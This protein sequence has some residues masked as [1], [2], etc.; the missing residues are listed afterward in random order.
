MGQTEQRDACLDAA[1]GGRWTGSTCECPVSG[2]DWIWVSGSPGSCDCPAGQIEKGSN[3]VDATTTT[4]YDT[5][6]VFV[7]AYHS[8]AVIG[9]IGSEGVFVTSETID[10]SDDSVTDRTHSRFQCWGRDGQ[11]GTHDASLIN[12][13]SDPSDTP[14]LNPS[15]DSFKA[16]NAGVRNSCYITIISSEDRLKCLGDGA[17]GRLGRVSKTDSNAPLLIPS[18]TGVKFVTAAYRAT[19]VIASN[20]ETTDD[21][22][23]FGYNGSGMFGEGHLTSRDFPTPVKVA[24]LTG[25]TH[26]ALADLTICAI[27]P[28]TSSSEVKCLGE[29]GLRQLG[30]G[31]SI[32]DSSMPQTVS[33]AEGAKAIS[34]GSNHFCIITSA[35][36]VACWGNGGTDTRIS[37]GNI[38]TPTE[39]SGVTGATHLDVAHLTSCFLYESKTKL[40]CIGAVNVD[41]PASVSTTFAPDQ[42]GYTTFTSV[43][44]GNT[45]VCV[46]TSDDKI[47]CLAAG[48]NTA[49][50][51][52]L[53]GQTDAI[54]PNKLHEVVVS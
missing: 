17:D 27:I 3:C 2:A 19:C 4:E 32:T 13:D 7:G 48:G 23:C 47:W 44:A 12:S 30:Q 53:I 50:N 14:S 22:Y 16:F 37:S 29:N 42:A 20:G 28:T 33:G 52:I 51:R 40:R 26:I 46:T 41:L 36:R 38:G 25:A 1:I 11:I 45:H 49:S 35:D 5:R 31:T 15:M 39:I 24:G 34:E 43:Q 21:V 18:L 8:C 54:T 9:D 10:N 6:H